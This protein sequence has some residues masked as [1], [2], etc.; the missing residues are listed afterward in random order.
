MAALELKFEGFVDEK[1]NNIL[2][3]MGGSARMFLQPLTDIYLHSDRDMELERTSDIAY[4]YLFAGIGLFI[5]LL[6]CLNFMNLSTARSANRAREVGL[7]KLGWDNNPIDQEIEVG[8]TQTAQK[9]I[10]RVVGVVEDYHFQSLHEQIGPVVLFNS[11]LYG[12]FDQISV[13]IRSENIQETL[14]YLE[15]QWNA[16]DSQFPFEFSFVDDLYDE[17]YRAEERMGKL[18]AYFTVLAIVIGCLGLFGLTSFTAEQRTKEIGVRK[19]LG[20]S[21]TGIT[22]LFVKEFTKWVLLAVVIAWPIGYFVMLNLMTLELKSSRQTLQS[23]KK[24]NRFWQVSND[25][26]QPRT[27]HQGEGTV[28]LFSR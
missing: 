6:A 8:L 28:A 9:R 17:L 23:W 13:R 4:V 11:C 10:Y 3:A 14:G 1:L 16:I 24:L 5:L 19:I 7:R 18:F 20:A 21:V 15:S 26:S 27:N 12:S 2:K 25:T 22:L